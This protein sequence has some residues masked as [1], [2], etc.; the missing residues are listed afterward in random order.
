[1]LIKQIKLDNFRNFERSDFSFDPFLTVI[2]GDNAQGK[3]NLLEAIYFLVNGIGFRESKEEEL[4]NFNKE[5]GAVEIIFVN[6]GN[7]N[8]SRINMTKVDGRVDKVYFLNKTK[9][10]HFQYLKEQTKAVL[11]SPEQIKMISDSPAIRRDYFNK[12]ISFYDLEYKK[13]LAN[14]EHAIKRRNK[15]LEH[16]H[17]EKKLNQELVF[18]NEFLGKQAVYLTKKRQAYV[19]F[20][21]HHPKLDSKL[22]K[23]KYLKDEWSKDRLNQSFELE[24]K[25]RRTVIGPQKDDFEIYLMNNEEKNLHHF[26]SRSEQRLAI[27]WL[28]TNEIQYHEEKFG[29]KPILLLDDIFSELDSHNRKMVLN[30]VKKYQTILTTTEKEVVE[31]IKISK[32]VIKLMIST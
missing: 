3:T 27:I 7:E 12:L 28:K 31:M 29:K 23:I 20:L 16:F 17:D 4:I 11:F 26:G 6:Q 32:V 8:N 5:R 13:R 1:M 24:K 9:K 15:I 19:D 25:I 22:F 21:N 2:I 18:W 30:L 10:N 14:Y